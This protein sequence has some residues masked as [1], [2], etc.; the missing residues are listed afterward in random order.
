M[1]R[2]DRRIFFD[3][4]ETYKA[5]YQLCE[6]KGVPKPT[7]GHILR[8]EQYPDNPLELEV[9][10]ENHRS[11]ETEINRYTKDF[12]VAALMGMC[13]SIGIPLPKGANKTLELSEEHVILR[14]QM[15]R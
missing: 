1:P 7:A 3:L 9:F 2:E 5:L 4:E 10:L 15:L 6:Q 11:N 14:L 13:R 8:V 12:M